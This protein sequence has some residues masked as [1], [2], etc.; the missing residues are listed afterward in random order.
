M[1]ARPCHE[2]WCAVVAGLLLLRTAPATAQMSYPERTVRLLYGFPPGAD[3]TA[4][5][6]ADKLADAW[7][8]PVIVENLTGAGG[9][10]AADRTAKAA[11]DGYTIG[12][13]SSSAIVI[14][15]SLY[16]KLTF[17]PIK[18]L[19]PVTQVFTYPNILAVNN[20]V[21]VRSVAELVALAR[22]EP[23]RLS[24]G[25]SGIGTT[26]HLAGELFK[27]MARIN[28]Q[29]IPYRGPTA[30]MPD[31][32]TGR[33]SMCFCNTNSVLPL[34][35][36]GKLRALAVTSRTRSRFAPDLPTMIELGYPDFDAVAWFGLFVP[37][38]TLQ[39]VIGKLHSETLRILT[40]PDVQT[41]LDNITVE[42][43]TNGPIEFATIIKA[44]TPYWAKVIKSSGAKLTE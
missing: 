17:D 30:V 10:I 24:F 23:G 41:K 25:H 15:V 21:P 44:E 1:R 38:G 34:L 28:L 8:R 43:V 33:V 20:D 7:G 26:Q 27:S 13:L 19:S 37:T 42:R 9:N 4:R 32:L 40:L 2:I 18:D 22:V 3:V 36:E 11:P 39:S 6:L 31:L 5:L 14:N 12:L 16:D 35:R 29:H